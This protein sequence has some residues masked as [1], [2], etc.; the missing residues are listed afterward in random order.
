ML[1]WVRLHEVYLYKNIFIVY[2]KFNLSL[3]PIFLF[4]K[5]M[6]LISESHISMQW[7]REQMSRSREEE[8]GGYSL[9]FR[10]NSKGGMGKTKNKQLKKK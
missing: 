7:K 9:V 10:P 1:T 6:N 8:Q 3:C 5:S 2:M 4:A